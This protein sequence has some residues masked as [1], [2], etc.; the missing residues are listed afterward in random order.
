MITALIIFIVG[1]F[2]TDK[3]GSKLWKEEK[4]VLKTQSYK[5]YFGQA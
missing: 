4:E 2:K 1:I 5:E 3:L